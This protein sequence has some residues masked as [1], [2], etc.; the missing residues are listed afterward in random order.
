MSREIK[1]ETVRV[2]DLHL[3]DVIRF[4]HPLDRGTNARK[5]N[6]LQV[7][8][9]PTLTHER[10]VVLKF[11]GPREAKVFPS[12]YELVELQ[13]VKAYPSKGA[14]LPD[15]NFLVEGHWRRGADG[16]EVWVEPSVVNPK[17]HAEDIL[18]FMEHNWAAYADF[19]T[20]DEADDDYDEDDANSG[21]E[22]AS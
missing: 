17:Q 6:W 14:D 4:T 15:Q 1:I 22:E 18:R 16:R 5:S 20:D 7:A 19:L 3:G 11:D 8:E 21:E 9:E 12:P 2:G 13:V 10:K